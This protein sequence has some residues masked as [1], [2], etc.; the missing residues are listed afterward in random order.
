MRSNGVSLVFPIYIFYFNCVKYEK[1]I[2]FCILPKAKIM[3]KFTK[4]IRTFATE[5]RQNCFFSVT[6]TYILVGNNIN[7]VYLWNGKSWRKH[8]WETFLDFVICHWKMQLRKLHFVIL[9][10]FLKVTFKKLSYL[11]NSKSQRK[12]C[13]GDICRFWHLTSNGV[14]IEKISFHDLDLLFDGYYF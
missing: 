11:S 2:C 7:F 5:W 10:N 13:V 14:K 9:T 12:K 6:L 4:H 3:K 8:V 1:L